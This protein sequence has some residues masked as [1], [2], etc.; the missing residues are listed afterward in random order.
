MYIIDLNGEKNEVTDLKLA[1]MQADDFRHY[2]L[3]GAQKQ[4]FNRKQKAYWEDFYQKLL[5]LEKKI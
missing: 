3:Q 1:L 5:V 4:E 2:E